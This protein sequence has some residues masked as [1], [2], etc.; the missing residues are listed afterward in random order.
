MIKLKNSDVE[1]YINANNLDFKVD[2]T[3]SIE[4]VVFD[5]KPSEQDEKETKKIFS[6]I[7]N[8]GDIVVFKTPEDN[9][10]DYIKRL[11]GLPGDKVQF[12]DANLYL[13]NSEI[14]K[15]IV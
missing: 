13:N 5:E 1:K 2:A 12:I 4:Y 3:R 15:S 9:R 11:I 10:T 7:P 14:M 8:R 6:N